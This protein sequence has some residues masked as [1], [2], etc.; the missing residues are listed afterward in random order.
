[1]LALDG[2]VVK[3]AQDN[4]STV[5]RVDQAKTRAGEAVG[6]AAPGVGTAPRS[7]AWDR[8]PFAGVAS[9]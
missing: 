5:C 3:N 7:P 6:A 9:G 1:M 8:T 4:H 2:A